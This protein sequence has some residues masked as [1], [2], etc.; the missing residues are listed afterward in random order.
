MGGGDVVKRY[1][2]VWFPGVKRGEGCGRGRGLEVRV[3]GVLGC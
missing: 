1:W 3:G 2:V